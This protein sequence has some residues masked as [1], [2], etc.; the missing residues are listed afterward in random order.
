MA[1]S[2]DQRDGE[3]APRSGVPAASRV[4]RLPRSAIRRVVGE[5]SVR[6]R[7]PTTLAI[8]L[9]TIGDL[10][11]YTDL[12]AK[13]AFSSSRSDGVN[14]AVG[15]QPTVNAAHAQ[16]SLRDEEASL[17]AFRALKRTAKFTPSLRDEVG[18]SRKIRTMTR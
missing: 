11:H 10:C 3:R 4:H 9:A 18:G 15:F 14:L 16:S 2:A 8:A 5:A 7:R 13:G 6:R 12:C 17:R 1:A